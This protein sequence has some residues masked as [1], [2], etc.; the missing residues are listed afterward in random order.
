MREDAANSAFRAMQ[1]IIDITEGETPKANRKND[2]PMRRRKNRK[3]SSLK[4]ECADRRA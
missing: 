3:W 1:H 2:V 4:S